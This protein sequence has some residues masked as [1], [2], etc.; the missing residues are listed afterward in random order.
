MLN[1]IS[2]DLEKRTRLN[3]LD[4]DLLIKTGQTSEKST[5]SALTRTEDSRSCVETGDD[6]N[7]PIFKTFNAKL[8]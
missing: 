2:D 7:L 6:K 4:K 8:K 1:R 5:E 3:L